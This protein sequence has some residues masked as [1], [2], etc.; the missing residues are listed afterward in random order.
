MHLFF[1]AHSVLVSPSALFLPF[2]RCKFIEY[3]TPHS[4]RAFFYR[5]NTSIQW[6]EVWSP[7]VQISQKISQKNS[8][9]LLWM[10]AACKVPR[11]FLNETL[12]SVTDISRKSLLYIFCRYSSFTAGWRCTQCAQ[13]VHA[14]WQ[15]QLIKH[16]QAKFNSVRFP[17]PIKEIC[18]L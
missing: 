12:H 18:F 8:T 6:L 16:N 13:T 1:C 5:H 17:L 2:A 3:F 11:I 9:T 7:C 4:F 14:E 15:E 10:C